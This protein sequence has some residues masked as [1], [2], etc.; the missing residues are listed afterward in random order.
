VSQQINLFNPVLLQQEKVFSA[1]TMMVALLLIAGGLG[2]LA[3]YSEH[4]FKNTRAEAARVAGEMQAAQRLLAKVAAESAPAQPEPALAAQIS[5]M[6]DSLRA[7][8][9]V[10]NF[11][12]NGEMGNVSGFS[13]YFRAFARHA[14]SNLWLTGFVID[15]A[16]TQIQIDGRT[17]EAE[18]VPRYIASLKGEQVFRGRSF[19]ALELREGTVRTQDGASAGSSSVAFRLSTLAS[20]PAGAQPPNLASALSMLPR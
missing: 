11:I 12:N 20:E 8:R 10:L 1:K 19:A 9:N 7:H 13:E 17:H 18:F 3:F 5:A 4:R 14:S 2:G 15:G 16:G 6:T